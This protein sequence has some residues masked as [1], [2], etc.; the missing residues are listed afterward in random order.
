MGALST[1]EFYLKLDNDPISVRIDYENWAM[2]AGHLAQA[3]MITEPLA[4]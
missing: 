3:S 4:A 2:A 1:K